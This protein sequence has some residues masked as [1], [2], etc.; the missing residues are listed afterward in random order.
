MNETKWATIAT[1]GNFGVRRWAEVRMSSGAVRGNCIWS[2]ECGATAFGVPILTLTKLDDNEHSEFVGPRWTCELLKQLFELAVS[3][4][5]NSCDSLLCF[6]DALDECE[7]SHIR[8]MV[9]FFESLGKDCPNFRVCL[10]GRHYPHITMGPRARTGARG[11]EG[12]RRR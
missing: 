4:L 9:P 8:D 7:E 11:S 3:Q 12:S 5:R 1:G 6:V 2:S 10:S